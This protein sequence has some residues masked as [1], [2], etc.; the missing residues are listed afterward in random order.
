[1]NFIKD[2]KEWRWYAHR[3]IMTASVDLFWMSDFGTKVYRRTL[4]AH[5]KEIDT[6]GLVATGNEDVSLR[7]PYDEAQT[8]MDEL[9]KAGLRPTN[10]GDPV[11]RIAQY[12]N[13][14]DWLRGHVEMLAKPPE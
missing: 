5:E 10:I 3:N 2:N 4:V 8:L 6:E 13:E 1:M 11:A 7:L 12:K 9:W 14:V